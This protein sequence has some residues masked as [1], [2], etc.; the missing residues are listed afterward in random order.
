MLIIIIIIILK[1]FFYWFLEKLLVFRINFDD[2]IPQLCSASTSRARAHPRPVI[3]FLR[4]WESKPSLA[5][6]PQVSPG[7]ISVIIIIKL[8]EICYCYSLTKH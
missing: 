4:V 2:I 7:Y 3:L 8:G 6:T 5:L 1:I